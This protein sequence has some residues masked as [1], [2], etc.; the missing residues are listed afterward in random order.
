MRSVCSWL[1]GVVLGASIV[2]TCAG[3]AAAQDGPGVDKLHYTLFDPTP[4]ALMREMSTDRPDTTESP[5]TVDAGHVQVEASFV[6]YTRD[7]DEGSIEAFSVLPM[8]VKLGLTNQID[9]QL[10]YEPYVH[11]KSENE[12]TDGFGVTQ[13]R[14][15]I[16]LWGNDGGD[17][18]FALMPFVQFPTADDEFGGTDKVEGGLILPLAISLPNEWSL[19]VMAELDAVR[20]AA[21]EDYEFQFVHT[22]TIGHAIVGELAGYIEYVGVVTTESDVDYIALVGGGLTYGVNE[23]VQ[24]DCGL[25]VGLSEDADDFNVFVGV[26]VRH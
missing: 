2:G 1:R 17:T 13:L 10:A 9:L 18:A 3:A 20:D 7:N 22:A 24:L 23:N 12:S 21:D 11:E 19:G 15:K 16:N 25:N 6:D 4:R 26:S 5:Y 14:L 8:N